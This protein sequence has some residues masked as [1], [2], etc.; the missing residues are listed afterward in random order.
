MPDDPTTIESDYYTFKGW[1]DVKGSQD[2]KYT[3]DSELKMPASDLELYAV[4]ERVS[5][6]LVPVVGS[7]TVIERNGVTESYNDNSVTTD[8]YAKPTN[9]NQYYIYG[10][11]NRR[12]LPTEDNLTTRYITYT[13]DGRIE[14]TRREGMES[15]QKLGTGTKVKLYDN[16]TG[17]VVEEF[18]LIY[19]GDVDGDCYV[20]TAD[21]N[22]VNKEVSLGRTW[23]S[24][25]GSSRILYMIKAA[26]LDG[27]ANIY[28]ADLN[29]FSKVVNGVAA[30]DQKTGTVS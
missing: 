9:Y 5:V 13:G 12:A 7:T 3:K 28:T 11:A 17:A 10:F 26:N 6:K 21:Y 2:V 14:I 22:L 30:I 23:S 15:A 27:S 24:L 8:S 20:T 19:F 25:R 18:Y 1:T 29:I 16:I 4:Y